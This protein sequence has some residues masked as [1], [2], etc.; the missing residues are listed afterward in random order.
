M[1]KVKEGI[2]QI[3]GSR[4][5]IIAEL[6]TLLHCFINDGILSEAEYDFATEHVKLDKEEID[7]KI[8]DSLDRLFNE[9]EGK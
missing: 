2:V 1:I 6:T 5:K 7:S 3:E 8:T 4:I 9:K